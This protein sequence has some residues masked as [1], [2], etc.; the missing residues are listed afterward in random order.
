MKSKLKICVWIVALVLCTICANFLFNRY[1]KPIKE[2][3]KYTAQ[4]TEKEADRVK[5]SRMGDFATTLPVVYIDTDDEMILKETKTNIKLAIGY[6]DG[7]AYSVL[8]EPSEAYYA[9]INHRGASS[10]SQFEKK[11]YRVEFYKDGKFKKKQNIGFLGMAENSEWVLN[12]PYLDKTLMRNKLVYDLGR[13]VMEWAPDS[14]YCELFL[15]GE[16]QGVYL[17]VEP[18]SVGDGRLRLSKFGLLS[19]STAYIVKR[20]RV[21]TEDSPLKNYGTINGKTVNELYLVYPSVKNATEKEIE[22]ITNR[23]SNFERALYKED[24]Y[25]DREYEQYLDIHNFVDYYLINEFVMNH[26]AGN[27]SAY[28]YSELGGKLSMA[29]WDYNNCFDNY[30]GVSCEFDDRYLSNSAWFDQ[31][32]KD[33]YFMDLVKDRYRELRGNLLSEEYLYRK[34]DEYQAY[35]GEAIDRNF[36]VWGFSF[37]QNLLINDTDTERDIRS[38]EQAVAQLENA[39]HERLLHLDQRYLMDSGE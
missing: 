16:Y 22:W 8:E 27:L 10:Y 19:G 15:N 4:W 24:F 23:V 20:D 26:D 5:Q 28:A 2:K 38:Y 30:Q 9:K 32:E 18:V 3:K 14:R 33:P 37:Y 6:S 36:E 11:Q 25:K 17:A 13:E 35:L 29:V 1:Q 39:I 31:L 21:G 12:G 7:E 34:L